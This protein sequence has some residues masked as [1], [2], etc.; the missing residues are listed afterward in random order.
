MDYLVG[1]QKVA[2]NLKLEPENIN[3]AS[4]TLTKCLKVIC[5]ICSMFHDWWSVLYCSSKSSM[6]A[7]RYRLGNGQL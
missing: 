2:G 5:T 1:Q 7:M 3:D 4:L 6:H